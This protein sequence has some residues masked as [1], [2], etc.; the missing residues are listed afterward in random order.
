MAAVPRLP[1][2]AYR[3]LRHALATAVFAGLSIAYTWPLAR[4]LGRA[5]SDPG[6]PFINIWILDWDW[7]ATRHQPLRLFHANAFHPAQYSLAFSE[8]LY[9]LAMLLFPLRM[10]G[11]GPITVFNVAMLAGFA[12]CGFTAY[13]LGQRLTGSFAAGLAAGI[14]YAFVPFRFV[15]LPHVQHI[16]GGW[17]PLLLLALLLYAEKPTV[18]RAAVFAAVFAMNG[19]TNIHYLL[20]GAFAIAVT[21]LLLIPRKDWRNLAIATGAALVVLAPFLYPY[22]AVVKLYGT[23]SYEETLRFSAFL[24]DWISNPIEPERKLFSGVLALICV[25]LAA[26]WLLGSWVARLLGKTTGTQQPSNPA[27]EQPAALLALL[28]ITIGFLGSLGLHFEF[29]RFLYGAVPGFRAVRVPARWAVI[30]YIGAAIL[31][32]LVTAAIARKNRWVALVVPLAFAIELYP[33]PIRWWM[34]N[35]ETPPVYTWLAGQGRTPIAEL[36]IDTSESEYVYLLRSTAH[37]RPM[38]NGISGFAP[39]SKLGFAEQWRAL[40]DDF[41]DSLRAAN[42][43]LVVVHTEMLG[44]RN[45]ETR[46][47]LQR[48]L[49][50]GRISFVRRFERD[51]VFA[52]RSGGPR[53]ALALWDVHGLQSTTGGIDYPQG[54][55]MRGKGHFS[56]WTKSPHG[57]RSVELVFENGRIRHPAGRIGDRFLLGFPKRPDDIRRD[58]DFQVEITDGRGVVTRLEPRWLRWE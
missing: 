49:D 9:G 23:R 40:S 12:F 33:G 34:T 6:D 3:L 35:A 19:L 54:R 52:L 31:I 8:N 18:K 1:P 5:V 58:T 38:I 37:H 28:W 50:R 41:I 11:A 47:W 48:E 20:F 45:R 46:D 14:F 29:H 13:L 55:L 27:T 17:L 42:V 32:A 44:P 30:A 15:H 2:T 56:G 10:F 7:W 22:A 43:E 57:I 25:I 16:W 39:K 4:H 21:A 53:N 26:I 36:P 24:S 51:W